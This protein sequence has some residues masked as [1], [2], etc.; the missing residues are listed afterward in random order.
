MAVAY[1]QIVEVADAF[2]TIAQSDA[3]LSAIKKQTDTAKAELQKA[4]SDVIEANAVLEQVKE[5]STRM[6]REA[7]EQATEKVKRAEAVAEEW[8]AKA[9]ADA[10]S[11]L[12]AERAKVSIKLK[13]VNAD[14]TT[15]TQALNALTLRVDVANKEASE[16]EERAKTSRAILEKIQEQARK[17]VS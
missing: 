14:I 15:A 11:Y 9:Q 2:D 12:E 16:A 7:D 10:K 13:A 1:Q 6:L 3:M 4:S 8:T 5:A 17:M